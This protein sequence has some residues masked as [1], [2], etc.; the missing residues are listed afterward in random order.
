MANAAWKSKYGE[1]TV[2]VEATAIKK[3]SKDDF[4]DFK[5]DL[6]DKY[7]DYISVNKI[8]EAYEVKVEYKFKSDKKDG[9]RVGAHTIVKYD[10]EW[11]FAPS[12][13][14]LD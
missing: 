5:S 14:D 12:G 4:A 1:Y 9:K 8:K 10:G 3:L 2:S 6:K 11:K 13:T 7:G